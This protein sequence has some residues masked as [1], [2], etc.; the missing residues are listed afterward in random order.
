MLPLSNPNCTK[1]MVNGQLFLIQ[2]GRLYSLVGFL[3]FFLHSLSKAKSL[4]A[5]SKCLPADFQP[6][7]RALACLRAA[8]AQLCGKLSQHRDAA[9]QS[10]IILSRLRDVL[11]RLCAIAS[12]SRFI[13]SRYCVAFAQFSDAPAQHCVVELCLCFILP[14]SALA[15]VI[16]QTNF[17]IFKF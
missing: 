4:V 16:N 5:K 9:S 14:L 1:S 8:L 17:L 10:R 13:L 2:Q 15:V 3:S 6:K 11:P 7:R 12:Q